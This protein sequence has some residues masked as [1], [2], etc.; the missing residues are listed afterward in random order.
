MFCSSCGTKNAEDAKFCTQC[1]KVFSASSTISTSQ[2]NDNYG[3]N[4]PLS[5]WNVHKIKNS[6]QYGGFKLSNYRLLGLLSFLFPPAGIVLYFVNLNKSELRKIQAKN[7][8]ITA[9][10]S[11]AF[12]FVYALAQ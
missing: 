4:K 6:E 1:G 7:L 9:I 12:G 8:L 5:I 10:I 11:I 3:L 2:S